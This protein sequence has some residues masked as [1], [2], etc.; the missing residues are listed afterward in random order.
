MVGRLVT[1][2]Y[3]KNYGFVS[4]EDGTNYFISSRTMEDKRE[5]RRVVVGAVIEY[6]LEEADQDRL[7]PMQGC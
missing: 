4:S 7:R 1:Y 3:K 6:T 2:F 5:Q